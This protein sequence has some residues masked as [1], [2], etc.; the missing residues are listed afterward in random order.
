[1][2]FGSV[3]AATQPTEPRSGSDRVVCEVTQPRW[4]CGF[5]FLDYHW[6]RP[7]RYHHPSRAAR[8]GTPVRSSVLELSAS[9]VS[10]QTAP[11]EMSLR[12]YQLR[13][14]VPLQHP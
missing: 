7:G 6:A 9:A 3:V 8:L 11:L 10:N 1:M 14:T 2:Q 12:N 5:P 4:N 13:I